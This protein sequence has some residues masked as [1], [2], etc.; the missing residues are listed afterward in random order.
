MATSTVEIIHYPP[1]FVNTFFKNF[2][3]SAFFI[4]DLQDFV[5]KINIITGRA[6]PFTVIFGVVRPHLTLFFIIPK[7]TYFIH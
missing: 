2:F 1:P 4:S 3:I 7:T 6:R 5:L